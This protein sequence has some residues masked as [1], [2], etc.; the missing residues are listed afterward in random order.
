MIHGVASQRSHGSFHTQGGAGYFRSGLDNKS[1]LYR[2]VPY[3]EVS[4]SPFHLSDLKTVTGIAL[5][6]GPDERVHD[7]EAVGSMTSRCQFAKIANS[8]RSQTSP[9]RGIPVRHYPARQHAYVSSPRPFG[10]VE[11]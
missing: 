1:L 4:S 3:P 2:T 11:S 8:P 5:H 7:N 10:T 6:S 9:S